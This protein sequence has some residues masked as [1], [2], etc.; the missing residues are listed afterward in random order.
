MVDIHF[1]QTITLKILY[2]LTFDFFY[3]NHIT[4]INLSTRYLSNNYYMLFKSY[5]YGYL[6]SS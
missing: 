4:K 2:I 3:I 6:V 1:D 5:F